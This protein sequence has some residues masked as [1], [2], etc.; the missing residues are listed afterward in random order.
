MRLSLK[1]LTI[2]KHF[3]GFRE[4][5]YQCPAGIWTIGFGTTSGVEAG[6]RVTPQEAEILLKADIA[7]YAKTINHYVLNKGISLNPNQYDALL[8]L[9]Y[10]TGPHAIFTKDYNNGYPSGSTLYNLLLERKYFNTANRFPDFCKVNGRIHQGLVRRRQ[11][12]RRLFLEPI[13]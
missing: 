3:E 4:D 5:A 12:E 1:G 7:K 6:M 9:V 13:Y 8:S 11:L 10:N 2:I